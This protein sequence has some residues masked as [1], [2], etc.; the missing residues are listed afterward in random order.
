MRKNDK[1]N[2]KTICARNNSSFRFL[3]SLVCLAVWPKKKTHSTQ[4]DE[5]FVGWRWET[6]DTIKAD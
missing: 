3:L 6:R 5:S 4:K 2:I 1:E